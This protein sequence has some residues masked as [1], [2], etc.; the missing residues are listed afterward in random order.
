MV[1]NGPKWYKTSEMVR[2][3]LKRSDMV[4]NGLKRSK[5]V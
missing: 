1:Q 2:N 3:V 5:M 4:R